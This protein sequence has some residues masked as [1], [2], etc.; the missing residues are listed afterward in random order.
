MASLHAF[1]PAQDQ[2]AFLK[3]SIQQQNR[4]SSLKQANPQHKW[5]YLL[6][7]TLIFSDKQQNAIRIVKPHKALLAKWLEKIIIAGQSSTI[8][9]EQM[10]LDEMNTLRLKQLCI[11][12]N[13]TLVNLLLSNPQQGTLIRGPWSL[14]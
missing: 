11:Q 4:L 10:E 13:V 2:S 9:V 14:S 7:D 8:F 12:H 6:A 5:T 1:A 3:V